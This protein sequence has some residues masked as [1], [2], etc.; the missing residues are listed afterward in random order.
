[1]DKLPRDVVILIFQFYG[2][3][4]YRRGEWVGCIS[5]DD[6]R[7]EILSKLKIPTPV[8]YTMEYDCTHPEHFEYAVDFHDYR[9]SVWNV[10]YHPPNK[11]QYLFYRVNDLIRTNEW[12]RY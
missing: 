6:Y 3:L 8:K 9:L 5:R 1:M 11:I 10:P 7:N 4:Q 2:R 12:F